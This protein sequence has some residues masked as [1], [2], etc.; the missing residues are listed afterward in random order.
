MLL[1]GLGMRDFSERS[2]FRRS[3][4]SAGAPQ[5]SLITS[6][7]PACHREP[8]SSLNGYGLLTHRYTTREIRILIDAGPYLCNRRLVDRDCTIQTTTATLWG[9]GLHGRNFKSGRI[10]VLRLV[11]W[12]GII[13]RSI[14]RGGVAMS[15]W[16]SA[17]SIILLIT[18]VALLTLRG[19]DLSPIVTLSAIVLI[20]LALV[21]LGASL[22]DRYR[23][24][25][26]Q[27]VLPT[28]LVPPRRFNHCAELA[29]SVVAPVAADS[30]NALR[31]AGWRLSSFSLG[32]FNALLTEPRRFHGRIVEHIRPMRMQVR[33]IVTNSL[34]LDPRRFDESEQSGSRVDDLESEIIFYSVVVIRKGEIQDQFHIEVKGQDNT[35][36]L[37]YEEYSRLQVVT[38][39]SIERVLAARLD[40][41]RIAKLNEVVDEALILICGRGVQSDN[42]AAYRDRANDLVAEI[43]S[44]LELEDVRSA[45]PDAEKNSLSGIGTLARNY[46]DKYPVVVALTKSACYD[47]HALVRYEREYPP[48]WC[49]QSPLGNAR[50]FLVERVSAL[51]GARPGEV[52]VDIR[53]AAQAQSYHVIVDGA[54]DTYVASQQI[55]GLENYQMQ[56]HD[57]VH[58]RF[59]RML[60]QSYV[61]GYFR[62]VVHRG[63]S[64]PDSLFLRVRFYETPPP[65]IA[66][67]SVSAFAALVLI[68]T[69]SFVFS[70][71]KDAPVSDFPA[72]ILAFPAIAAAFVG[73][74]R[75]STG[76]ILGTELAARA[77]ALVTFVT[78][79]AATALYMTQTRPETRELFRFQTTSFTVIG[80]DS[81][82]WLLLVLIAATNFLWS[83][84]TWFGRSVRF[85]TLVG[86]DGSTESML[87]IDVDYKLPQY[88]HVLPQTEGV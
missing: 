73:V 49:Y 22:Y 10:E 2:N 7:Q 34:L 70:V 66:K 4:S 77:C 33:Q 74:E 36:T 55:S 19:V 86:G 64:K 6:T 61:H 59:R 84:T 20:L 47:G 85:F 80:I 46:C 78:S 21:Q 23:S 56:G 54:T 32:A 62:D 88:R 5:P 75:P 65:S 24:D 15:R 63:N 51:L 71:A 52:E 1:T 67:A 40:A 29:A 31:V 42:Y 17:L 28:P 30:P 12:M 13:G 41:S 8:P 27:S 57:N 45:L 58:Y 14:P 69:V 72:L 81:Y 25:I 82:S 16:R 35:F 44:F 37:T 50:R 26:R 48:R 18:G 87:P 83:A 43:E 53:R 76:S 3:A 38:L 60:G 79:L 11:V 39:R 9:R 68:L